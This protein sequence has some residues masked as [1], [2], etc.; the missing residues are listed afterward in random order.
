MLRSLE[1]KLESLFEGVF[2]RAFRTNVQPVEL[3]RK[4]VKEMDDHRNVSVSRVYVPNEYTIYLSVADREQFSS[5]EAQLR[6][7]LGDYLAE[8]ARRESYV[9][10]SP[11]KVEIDTD[12]DLDVGV[13]GIATR[14]VQSGRGDGPDT[15]AEPNATMVYKPTAAAPGATE[16]ASPV[17]LGIQREVAVLE[18]DGKRHEISKRRVV[19]GRSKDA[20][21]QVSDPNIS[22]R[23]AELRQEGATYWLVDLD[24][25]NGVEV[26]G[27]RVKRLKLEDGTQFTIG[28]TELTFSRELQ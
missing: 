10:L 13:F 1:S 16:A 14:M 11:P 18:W 17:D 8:H 22:R 19:I 7:E 3:A 4:L 12:E 15:D 5:Y 20:D 23:H 26:N 2:G 6:D 28:S 9:L 24:S 21:V 27:Q 25:T